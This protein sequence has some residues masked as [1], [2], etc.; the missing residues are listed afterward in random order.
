M[1]GVWRIRDL[2]RSRQPQFLFLCEI[3]CDE[4]VTEKIKLSCHFEGCFTVRSMGS[5]GGLCLF[6]KEKDSVTIKS[7]SAN[8]IDSIIS[9]GG[10]TWKFS[11]IYGHPETGKKHLTCNLLRS[12]YDGGDM[13]WLVG[14]DLNEILR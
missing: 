2:V 3:K 1:P 4:K 9:L 12:L 7:Y 13:S 14:G 6:W 5:S 11:G 10:K 8:H